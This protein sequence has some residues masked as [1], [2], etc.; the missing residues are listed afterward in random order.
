MARPSPSVERTVAVL[1]FLAA[2]PDEAF[3]L[4]ELCRRVDLTKATGHA[5]LNALAEAGYLLRHPSDK[6]FT[7]GPALIAIGSAAAARR[8]QVVD[9]AREEMRRLAAD[10]GVQVLAS[11]AMGDEIVMLG[12]SGEPEPFGVSVQ[13]GQ[14]LPLVPPLG[15]VFVAWSGPDEID[16]WLRRV[17]AGTPAADLDRYRAAVDAVRRRGWSVGLDPET[18]VRLGAALEGEA[19]AVEALL[20]QLGHQEY[21]LLELERAASYRLS[22]IAAPVFGPDGEVVLAL[23]LIGFRGELDAGRIPALGERLQAAALAVTKS[24]HGRAPDGGGPDTW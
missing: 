2:H 14:R 4:S 24:I 16:R 7:L 8:M 12:R 5:M 17:G 20:D 15:T 19:A 3:T 1:D 11:A 23:T 21:S 6:T 13:V 22:H 18:R 10:L 9:H